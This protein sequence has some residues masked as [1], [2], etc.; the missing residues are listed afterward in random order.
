MAAD[1]RGSG[2]IRHECGEPCMERQMAGRSP[3]R[4]SF[5]PTSVARNLSPGQV[6]QRTAMSFLPGFCSARTLSC[7]SHCP[8]WLFSLV[9]A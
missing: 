6:A 4:K 8:V 9:L 5:L 7:Q 3:P 1:T 2:L